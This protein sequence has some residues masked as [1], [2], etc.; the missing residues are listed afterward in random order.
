MSRTK[1]H[2]HQRRTHQGQ[3]YGSR[4]KCNKHYGSDYGWYA[5]FRMHKELRQEDKEVVRNELS[6]EVP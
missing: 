5:R 4:H 1:H 3:S 6:T 2:R